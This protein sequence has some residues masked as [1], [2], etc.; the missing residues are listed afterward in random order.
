L[1]GDVQHREPGALID[2]TADDEPARRR[3]YWRS[4]MRLTCTML[5]IWFVATFVVVY[6]A[7]ELSGIIFFGWPLSFYMAAQGSLL[8]YVVIVWFLARRMA[9]LDEE[10][11]FAED[12]VGESP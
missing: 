9:R 2:Q 8:I 5:A 1:G 12:D 7:R 10:H 4:N 11:G 6:F 3:A